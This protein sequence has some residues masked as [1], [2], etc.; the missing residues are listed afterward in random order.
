MPNSGNGAGP[1][2]LRPVVRRGSGSLT[3]SD[4]APAAEGP[5]PAEG[6]G[7]PPPAPRTGA[8]AGS[9]ITEAIAAGLAHGTLDGATAR[10]QLIEHA[11]RAQLPPDA[12]PATIAAVRAE[13]EALLRDDPLLDELLRP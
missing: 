6:T 7:S 3:G 9:R 13:V 2:S 12:S 11:V 1:G 4:A 8:V 5:G 10:A